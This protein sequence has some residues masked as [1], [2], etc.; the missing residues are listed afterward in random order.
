LIARASFF[1][2]GAAHGVFALQAFRLA[3]GGG[4]GEGQAK[5]N[6]SSSV[7]STPFGEWILIA[8][9]LAVIGYAIYQLYRAWAA[10]LGKQLR[11]TFATAPA[12]RWII[13]ICRMGIASRGVVFALIGYF[14][15]Q[16]G[17]RHDP[18]QNAG[19]AGALRAL[20][21][22]GTSGWLFPVVAAGL[23]AYGIYE[24]IKARYRRITT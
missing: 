13:G 8:A 22:G 5:E 3:S 20:D 21:S 19:L 11:L 16:A 23:I 15:V 14:L 24:F 4:G 9:G 17:L 7:M 1:V 2:R 12:R 6:V 10:K 18:S